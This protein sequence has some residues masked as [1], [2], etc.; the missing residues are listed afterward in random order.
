M[1]TSYDSFEENKFQLFSDFK[2]SSWWLNIHLTLP[3]WLLNTV[4]V[5]LIMALIVYGGS[6]EAAGLAPEQDKHAQADQSG[7][8]PV[9]KEVGA[10]RFGMTLNFKSKKPPMVKRSTKR[11]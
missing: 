9:H 8:K 4:H 11:I 10:A 7:N 3:K 1:L 5:M 2:Y 6:S